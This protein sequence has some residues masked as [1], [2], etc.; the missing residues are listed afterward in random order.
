MGLRFRK[1]INLGNG[2]RINLSKSG[3]SLSFGRKGLRG[4]INTK[5]RVTGTVGLPGTGISY[6][7]TASLGTLL[8]GGAAAAASKKRS[9]ARKADSGTAED[10]TETTELSP[11]EQQERYQQTLQAVRSIHLT[12]DEPIDWAY[13]HDLPEPIQST[14]QSQDGLAADVRD[15][16]EHAHFDN[17]A[18]W[19]N[20]HALSEKVLAGDIDSYLYVIQ[21]MHPFDDLLSYGSNFECGTD[22]PDAME[23]EFQVHADQVIPEKTVTL[24]EKGN[25]SNRRMSKSM[26]NDLIQDY[27]CSSVIRTAREIFAL[28]PVQKVLVNAVDTVLNTATGHDEEE[29]LVSVLFDRTAFEQ[30]DFSR[31]DPSDL[32][33]AY[34]H[35][36]AFTK[37]K[38]MQP[39]QRMEL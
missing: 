37:T 21:E 36:M 11:A 9:S 17:H 6:V 4:T 5:G 14:D 16:A 33:E 7:K 13:L 39:V 2:L 15:A 20:L 18:E 10:T 27:I 29:T 8:G 22:R 12:C 1:S 23:V 19:E 35:R 3:L 38:G 34:P 30:T 32:I 24:T 28:L 26:R 25:V 31:I